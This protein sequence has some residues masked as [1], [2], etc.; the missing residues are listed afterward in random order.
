VRRL[1]VSQALM[2]G[3]TGIGV[4][5]AGALAATRVLQSLLFGIGATDP[6][7]FAGVCALLAGVVAAAAYFPA[8][9][10]TR[11]DPLLALRTD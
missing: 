6:A 10:A 9:R 3:A 8:R 4:G 7:T 11:V 5:L 1:I 2:L